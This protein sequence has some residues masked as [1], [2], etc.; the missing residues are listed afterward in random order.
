MEERKDYEVVNI[1]AHVPK[2][3]EVTIPGSRGLQGEVGPQGP[4]GEP[5]PRGDKGDQGPKGDKGDSFTYSDFTSEQL[6]RLKGPKGDKGEPGKGAS[7]DNAYEAL[8]DGNVWVSSKSVDD[9]LTALI[10]HLGNAFPWTG[11][12]PLTADIPAE[13]DTSITVH[14]E[15][16][17]AVKVVGNDQ[18]FTI[19][20]DGRGT[21]DI[22]TFEHNSI[23]LTY[24]NYKGS[25]VGTL[26][27]RGSADQEYSEN[28]IDYKLYGDELVMD[29]SNNYVYGNFNDNPK[30]WNISKTTLTSNSSITVNLGD[31]TKKCG[32]YY[33][34]TPEFIAFQCSN[35][36]SSITVITNEGG[37]QHIDF[38]NHNIHWDSST[39]RYINDGPING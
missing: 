25:Q 10:G 21:V 17:Y 19:N 1:E 34:A 5:G 32:P 13:G 23:T 36:L 18:A 16:H 7:A 24:H 3:I 35:H 8:L 2:V 27:V 31:V 38:W 20:D 4:Q 22:P 39:A 29:I 9:V 11:F 37:E 30:N 14:G 26:V 28:G 15:P 6:E 12:T 33:I